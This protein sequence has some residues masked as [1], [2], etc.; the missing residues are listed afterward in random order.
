MSYMVMHGFSALSPTE[1]EKELPSKAQCFYKDLTYF[2]EIINTHFRQL[3]FNSIVLNGGLQ[4][5]SYY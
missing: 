4:Y 3:D 2:T 5:I 1:P